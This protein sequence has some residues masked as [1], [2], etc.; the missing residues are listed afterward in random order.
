MLALGERPERSDRM[1]MKDRGHVVHR[2][3]SYAIP[4]LIA[5][6]AYLSWHKPSS[7]S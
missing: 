4:F 6:S 1:V 7:G 5:D 2:D 3:E